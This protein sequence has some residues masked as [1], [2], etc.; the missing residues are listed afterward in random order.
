MSMRRAAAL[1]SIGLA[2]ACG[3][4]D[5]ADGSVSQSG[6]G[7][8]GDSLTIALIGKSASN[9]VFVAARNGADSAARELSQKY[10]SRIAI[11]WITPQEED[12]K[13]QVEAVR[14]ATREKVKAILISASDAALLTA[15]IN[16]AVDQGIEVMTFDS[17]AP[18]SRRFAYYGIDDY[19]AGRQVMSELAT[20]VGNSGKVAIL[21]GN[22]SAG[23]L[24][25][26]AKGA[27]DEAANHRGLQLVGTFN[28]RETPQDAVAEMQR[29]QKA[30]PDLKGW[31]MVGS[32]PLFGT[33]LL[34]DPAAK[35]SRIVAVD[36]LPAE[37]AYV[38]SGIA[39]VLLAQPVYQWG[40][41]GVQTI[42]DKIRNKAVISQRIPMNL[43]RVN[44]ENLKPWAQQLRDWGFKDVPA[45]YLQ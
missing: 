22:Q 27:A 6:A 31:A 10:N 1:A 17:D 12:A 19:D 29:V 24:Q 41:V 13:G 20:L 9:P 30:H 3:K 40:Y 35:R 37:L 32:W 7:A 44:R 33:A 2:L 42:V 16:E 4:G 15:P 21:A 26:R 11:R 28:H 23:N 39:P 45:K 5:S 8:A 36:A 18:Q 25:A 14:V 43:V 34:N 38:E